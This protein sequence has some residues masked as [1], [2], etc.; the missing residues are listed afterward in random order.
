MANVLKES[1]GVT[2]TTKRILDLDVSL[3][4]SELLASASGV[5]KQ[6]TKAL[7]E[8]EVVQFRVN[9]LR[10]AVV[11]EANLKCQWYTMGF[12]ETRV[13]LEDS[14]KVLA[15]LD[16]G[17]EINVMTKAVMEEASLVMRSGS[18]LK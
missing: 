1:V 11:I 16:T 9:S 5:E 8:D 10:V 14:A 7:S 18:R 15:L 17:A 2:K 13:C 4:V 6:L 12:A 3:T